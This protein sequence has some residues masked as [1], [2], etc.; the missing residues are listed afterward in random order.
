ML[1]VV[2]PNQSTQLSSSRC[3]VPLFQLWALNWWPTCWY[4]IK[5]GQSKTLCCWTSRTWPEF[6]IT[7]L[8]RLSILCNLQLC[9]TAPRQLQLR[10]QVVSQPAHTCVMFKASGTSYIIR[11][12]SFLDS[13]HQTLGAKREFPNVKLS[14]SFGL[15]CTFYNV[16]GGVCYLYHSRPQGGTRHFVCCVQVCTFFL[17]ILCV[18]RTKSGLLICWF[19]LY[20]HECFGCTCVYKLFIDKMFCFC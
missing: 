7:A 13:W 10:W 14:L 11:H 8:W 16:V 4:V 17:E 3:F 20:Y 5:W 9:R 18:G 6:G 15:S 19:F 2:R 12:R 1:P